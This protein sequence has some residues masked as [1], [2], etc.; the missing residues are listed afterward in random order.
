M[1]PVFLSA[2][3]LYSSRLNWE[4]DPPVRLVALVVVVSLC[5]LSTFDCWLL[6]VERRQE[7]GKTKTTTFSR[8][9]FSFDQ[10]LLPIFDRV[11]LIVVIFRLELR[12]KWRRRK[13]SGEKITC[14]NRAASAP[15]TCSRLQA[16]RAGRQTET[17]PTG[18]IKRRGNKFN[19]N[20]F[21]YIIPSMNLIKTS[22]RFCQ[23]IKWL[24]WLPAC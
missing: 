14:L 24:E 13:G 3:S 12:I 15:T 1:S 16:K 9:V 20:H 2:A 22:D 4:R 18:R 7:A 8:S 17:H 19:F 5:R 23:P 10:S 21:D 6:T 11:P